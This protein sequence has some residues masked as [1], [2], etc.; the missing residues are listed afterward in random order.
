M[1]ERD[2]FIDIVKGLGIISVVIGHSSWRLF[3]GKIPIGPF[4]YTYHLMLFFFVAGFCFSERH[5]RDVDTYIGQRLR[6]ML[7]LYILYECIFLLLHN[8]LLKAKIIT[9]DIYDLTRILEGIGNALTARNSE[10]LLGAMWFIPMLLIANILFCLFFDI[11]NRISGWMHWIFAILCGCTGLLLCTRNI[12]LNYG[13]QISLLAVPV[14]YVGYVIKLNW[15]R[16][17]RWASWYGCIISVFVISFILGHTNGAI[18]E[19]SV[20]HIISPLLF[21]PTTF[22]GIYFCLSLARLLSKVD[23]LRN[24][25]AFVGKNSFHI[26]ALHLL[27]LKIIDRL[28]GLFTGV[29]DVEVL[30]QYP[31]S[32]SL[33]PLYYLGGVLIP[34]GMIAIAEKMKRYVTGG[35]EIH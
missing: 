9:G 10:K 21:Y 24:R 35:L 19:L 18:I 28:Y 17:N 27:S 13:L 25:M 15:N 31:H 5:G 6:K 20:N 12:S 32:F 26:M 11:A 7:S 4:V 2:P 34:L 16:V 22:A 30:T 8:L 29:T 1:K 23:F 33:E 3:G 14:M